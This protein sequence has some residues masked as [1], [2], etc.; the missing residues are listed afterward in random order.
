MMHS[1]AAFTF[2]LLLASALPAAAQSPVSITF[3]NGNVTVIARDVP[4]RT[5]L[6]EWARVGGSKIV[7]GERVAGPAVTLELTNV[8]E[9]QAL[10]VLL[11]NVTNVSGHIAAARPAGQSGGSTLDRIMVLPI[12]PPAQTAAAPVNTARPPT[13]ALPQPVRFLGGDTE[14]QAEFFINGGVP[15][16]VR[17]PVAPTTPQP[18]PAAAV[19]RDVNTSTAAPRATPVVEDDDA[20]PRPTQ[21]PSMPTFTGPA[22]S[23]RPG[24]I[25]PVPQQRNPQEK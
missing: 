23:G 11:R 22:G 13:T 2:T 20:R 21:L 1:R 7:N 14:D 10:A 5:I 18:Q 24:E 6:A 3:N 25:S 15:A 19:V 8:P 12:A 9:R 17:T 4:V 16:T